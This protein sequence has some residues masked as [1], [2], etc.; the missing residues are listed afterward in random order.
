MALLAEIAETEEG[1][2]LADLARDTTLSASTALRLLRALEGSDF[3]ERRADGRYHVGTRLLQI[4]VRAVG[5]AR[6]ISV[7]RPYLQSLTAATGES[8]YLGIPGP[9]RSVLY[10]ANVESPLAVRH[11]SWPGRLI[12]MDTTA[13]GAALQGKVS[14]HG[15][16][17]S[18]KTLDDEAIAIAVPIHDAD[19]IV[20]AISV[21]G[22]KYRVTPDKAR[23]AGELLVAAAAELS[24]LSLMR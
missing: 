19:V 18:D 4:G 14:G 24:R 9:K 3:V 5:N 8:S 20:A 23:A 11:V 13:I 16:A 17:I 21:V 7:V 12:P 1:A 2:R 10:V 22:P 15:Y 6:W